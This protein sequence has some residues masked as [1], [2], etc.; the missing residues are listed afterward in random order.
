MK[1]I[2]QKVR[3]KE[4]YQKC[5]KNYAKRLNEGNR[6]QNNKFNATI[7]DTVLFKSFSQ[8]L[9]T[10]FKNYFF[11]YK[12]SNFKIRLKNLNFHTKNFQVI[13]KLRF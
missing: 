13:Y 12:K 9:K 1:K 11:R 8:N 3:K 2:K 6:S 5:L 7:T 4:E 10:A